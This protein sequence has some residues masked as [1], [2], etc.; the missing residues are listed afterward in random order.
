[1]GFCSVCLPQ[2][3]LASPFRPTQAPS[4]F[5]ATCVCTARS[6]VERCRSLLVPQSA[7]LYRFRRP[8][9]F[10]REPKFGPAGIATD[11]AELNRSNPV[12]SLQHRLHAMQLGLVKFRQQR[13]AALML[14]ISVRY[15][16]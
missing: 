2:S 12:V 9:F 16:A 7:T 11:T 5:P 4:A 10:T 14:R 13:P 1:M 3:G 15:V 6:T 8:T